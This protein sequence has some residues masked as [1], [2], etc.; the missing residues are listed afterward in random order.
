[1]TD[2][3]ISTPETRE[4]EVA[5]LREEV[6]RLKQ[7]RDSVW[8]RFTLTESHDDFCTSLDSTLL[9]HFERGEQINRLTAQLATVETERD[10]ERNEKL[11]AAVLVHEIKQQLAQVERERDDWKTQ[12]QDI[13]K[14]LDPVLTI[15][16]GLGYVIELKQQLAASEARADRLYKDR[17]D[18]L[19]VKS[20]DGL[21][22]SE[23]LM[24][25]ATAEARCTDAH[26]AIGHWQGEAHTL[27]ARVTALSEALKAINIRVQPGIAVFQIGDDRKDGWWMTD[28]TYE[29]LLGNLD[30]IAELAQHALAAPGEKP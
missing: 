14:G 8:L 28:F 20:T 5:R 25:T 27:Q 7:Q 6:E 4:R 12:V 26:E 11:N 9:E 30:S 29:Q 19:N 1:M 23:W 22:S 18:L 16:K 15:T 2:Q 13:A 17:Y 10:E 21:S 24:R 3:T